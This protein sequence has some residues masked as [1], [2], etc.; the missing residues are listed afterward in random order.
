MKA[1]TQSVLYPEKHPL[2][3]IEEPSTVN[4]NLHSIGLRDA[5]NITKGSKGCSKDKS[6]VEVLLSN[7]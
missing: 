7:R 2:I 4:S 3:Q 6:S 5:A 1:K